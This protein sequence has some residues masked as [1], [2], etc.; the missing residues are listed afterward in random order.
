MPV[1]VAGVAAVGPGDRG[2]HGGQWAV[3]IVSWN[4]DMYALTSYDDI[5]DAEADDDVNVER[6]ADLDFLCPIQGH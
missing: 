4:V 3:Y 1:V 6:N 2:Y 5:M